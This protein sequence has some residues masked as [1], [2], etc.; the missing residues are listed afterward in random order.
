MFLYQGCDGV[1]LIMCYSKHRLQIAFP[2]LCTTLPASCAWRPLQAFNK[3]GA[4]ITQ[5]GRQRKRRISAV[6]AGTASWQ[7]ALGLQVQ[8]ARLRLTW[9]R[10][11]KKTQAKREGRDEAGLT[12]H[13]K[14][15]TAPCRR[16]V[17]PRSLTQS[18]QVV[19]VDPNVMPSL[20]SRSNM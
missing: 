1:T 7:R 19:E 5:R 15:A 2:C 14:A 18:V 12:R 4:G 8:T 17:P 16:T 9:P 10:K 3:A 6:T 11:K 13:D 20:M